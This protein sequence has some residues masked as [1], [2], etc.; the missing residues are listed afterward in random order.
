MDTNQSQ[1][2]ERKDWMQVLARAGRSN[3]EA[4]CRRIPSLPRYRLVRGPEVGM[5]MVQA[6]GGGVGQPFNMGEATVTRCTLQI[7]RGPVG[8]AYVLGRDPRHAELAALLDALLQD[9]VRQADLVESVVMPLA[10]DL[11]ARRAAQD[12]KTAATKVEFFTMV[13]GE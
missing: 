8:T 7:D 2:M 9:P 6:R 1:I 11:R 12:R 13:R 4:A 3:L 5:V 10:S